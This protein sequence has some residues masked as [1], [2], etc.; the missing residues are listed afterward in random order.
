MQF[1]HACVARKPNRESLEI[2]VASNDGPNREESHKMVVEGYL[3]PI[4]LNP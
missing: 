3:H 4:S 1:R 2:R